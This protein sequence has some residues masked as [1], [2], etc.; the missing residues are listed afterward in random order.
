MKLFFFL[1]SIA[2]IN[3]AK[4]RGIFQRSQCEFGKLLG[5]YFGSSCLPGSRSLFHD[6]NAT[7]PESLCNLCQT[8]LAASTIERHI[9]PMADLVD[10]NASEIEGAEEEV[11]KVPLTPNHSINCEAATTNRFYGTR[12]ALSCLNEV[13]EIAILEH[14]NLAE[15]ARTLNLNQNDFRIL[16]RNGSLAA[17]TGFEVDLGCFLTTI[18]DGEVVMRKNDSKNP[19]IINALASLDKYLQTDPD[20]KMYNIFQGEKNL[21]FEDSSLGLV[22]PND[23]NL[24]QSV[25]NYIQLFQDVENCFEETGGATATAINILLTFSLIT[26]TVLIQN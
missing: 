19:G 2:F 12:G 26:I 6:Q 13:G 17:N 7:N 1:A 14:Q 10:E 21:L 9:H 4:N 16:C 24:G 18:V 23:D 25:K 15:H 20:F 3:T 22:S 11:Q 5:E 8:Q